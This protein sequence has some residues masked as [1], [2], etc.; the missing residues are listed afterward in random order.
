LT[1]ALPTAAPRRAQLGRISD[2]GLIGGV[3]PRD[4]SYASLEAARVA[5]G[6]TRRYAERMKPSPFGADPAVVYLKQTSR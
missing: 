2:F 5:M 3:N 4:P 6:D 1:K